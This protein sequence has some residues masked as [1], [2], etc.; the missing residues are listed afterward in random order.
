[1]DLE[2]NAFTGTL[3]A[4]E[5]AQMTSLS[6]LF[7]GK[8][9]LHSGTIPSALYTLKSMRELSLNSLQLT[10]TI[11][12]WLEDFSKL[13]LLDL[14]SNSLTGSLT[15]DFSKLPELSYLMINDNFL[16]GHVPE[17]LGSDGD[18]FVVALHHN[19]I[20]GNAAEICQ[21][22]VQ[23]LTTDCDDINCPCC[24]TCC[25][26]GSCYQDLLWDELEYSQGAWEENFVRSTYA[27][28]PHILYDS[29]K[30]GTKG[31]P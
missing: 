8:N 29:S 24:K 6:Y 20:T 10:G 18:L 13:K 9:P 21:K 7:L 14:R 22:G 2:D 1:L 31:H 19:N 3:P 12:T 11:P 4:R 25:D 27:F 15:L 5:L 16:N 17:N 26:S 28:N 30:K 23:L